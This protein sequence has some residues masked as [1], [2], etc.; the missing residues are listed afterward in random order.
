MGP[1]GGRIKHP[2]QVLGC[3]YSTA[4]E[5]YLDEYLFIGTGQF[6]PLGIALATGKRVVTADPIT[7]EVC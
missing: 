3:C 2:G 7:C 4:R 1:A 5:L 6:H